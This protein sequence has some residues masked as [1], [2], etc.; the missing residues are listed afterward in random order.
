M[1]SILN[2]LT[3]ALSGAGGLCGVL[4]GIAIVQIPDTALPALP[5]EL[6]WDYIVAAFIVSLLIGMAA[7]V[8][9]AMKAARLEPLKAL[10]AE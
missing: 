6:A 9:P 3:L 5:V 1:D 7:G 4:L 8:A 2:I 10:R